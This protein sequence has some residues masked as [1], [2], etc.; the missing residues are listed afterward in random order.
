[1]GALLGAARARR[2]WRPPLC[3]VVSAWVVWI[4]FAPQAA[5]AWCRMTTEQ[6]MPSTSDQPCVR[7]GVAL[8]WRRRCISYALDE[9]GASSLPFGDVQAI[10]RRSFL[11][12]TA[13]SCGNAL[14]GLQ[15]V[16][17]PN[18]ARCRDTQFCSNGPNVNNVAFVGDWF[19]R[20]VNAGVPGGYDPR[21]YA[22][23]T[24]NIDL[25]SGEI[26]DADMQIN[27]Q[28]A[29]YVVCPVNVVPNQPDPTG[30]PPETVGGL[31]IVDLENVITHE[32]GHFFGLAHTPDD[33]RATMYARTVPGEVS[34]RTLQPDDVGGYCEA[35]PPGSL[36]EACDFTPYGGVDLN[37]EDTS[38]C[39]FRS[40]CS[41]R[42]ASPTSLNSM[43]IAAASLLALAWMLR[44]PRRRRR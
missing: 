4:L 37:C 1:M 40:N 23:T 5:A 27:E 28:N 31:D 11:A 36:P 2:G 18:T 32:A 13:Q 33:V 14:S 16:E 41:C 35:Y 38:E 43:A 22:V 26:L 3:V 7:E 44:L 8:A 6:R 10:V 20:G 42:L 24:V 21:A 30:C 19:Q 29:R 34:K 15:V 39:E 9:R 25:I 12:W 17:H